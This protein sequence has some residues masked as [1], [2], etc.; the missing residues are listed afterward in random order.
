[1]PFQETPAIH[2]EFQH[3]AE[4]VTEEIYVV[5]EFSR[6]DP[7][8]GPSSSNSCAYWRVRKSG[9]CSQVQSVAEQKERTQARVLIK[10]FGTLDIKK[11]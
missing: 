3:A 8:P 2:T 1:M 6:C 11:N 5:G 10:R 7:Q 4:I 9:V